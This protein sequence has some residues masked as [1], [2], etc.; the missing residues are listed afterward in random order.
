MSRLQHSKAIPPNSQPPASRSPSIFSHLLPNQYLGNA[1]GR[2]N[3]AGPARRSVVTSGVGDNRFQPVGLADPG[4]AHPDLEPEC[5]IW[6]AE[7]L[8]DHHLG[9]PL[10]T[11]VEEGN[12]KAISNAS[13]DLDFGIYFETT[14]HSQDI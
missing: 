12:R 9:D 1:I 10:K 11:R 6:E 3:H 8:V 13:V 14:L 4:V 2:R 7:A 5:A